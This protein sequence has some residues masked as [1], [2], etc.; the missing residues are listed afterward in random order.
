MLLTL[1]LMTTL[2]AFVFS[3]QWLISTVQTTSM[4]SSI[5]KGSLVL[6]HRQPTV[7][8][9]TGQ[10]AMYKFDHRQSVIHRVVGVHTDGNSRTTIVFKGDE[11]SDADDPV[12]TDQVVGS[13]VGHVPLAGNAVMFMRSWLGL[14]LC[15]YIPA[16]LFISYE[17]NRLARTLAYEQ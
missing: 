5:P 17:V 1:T 3:H 4:Q 12:N 10:V 16:I 7:M 15:V 8:I 14:V 9:R 11:N 2:W 13:V 6:I